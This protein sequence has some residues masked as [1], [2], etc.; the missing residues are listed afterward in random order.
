MDG[1]Y[2]ME[3]KFQYLERKRLYKK[4]DN[5]KNVP[6]TLFVAP[7]GY[8]KSS[9]AWEYL[10][11]NKMNFCWISLGHSPIEE[12][13]L[14]NRVVQEIAKLSEPLSQLMLQSGLPYGNNWEI[15]ESK[16]ISMIREELGPKDFYLVLDDYHSCNGNKLSRFLTKLAY[17]DI[18]GVHILLISRRY[19]DLPLEELRLKGYCTTINQAHIIMSP[20]EMKQLFELNGMNLDEQHFREVYAYTDGWVAAAKLLWHDYQE[21]KSIRSFGSVQRL[22]KESLYMNLSAE[23]RKL[24]YAFTC[25]AELSVDELAVVTNIPITSYRLNQLMEKT[26]F[27][28]YNTQNQKYS[29]NTLLHTVILEL[30][31][32]NPSELF[33]RYACYQEKQQQYISALEYYEKA[34]C[35]EEILHILDSEQRFEIMNQITDF[36]LTFFRSCKDPNE[37]FRHPYAVLS[38]IYMMLQSTDE[39]IILEG[40]RFLTYIKEYYMSQQASAFQY[41]DLLGELYFVDSLNVFHDLTATN[42]SL[43]QAWELRGGKSSRI[44]AKRPYSY[45]VPNTLSMYHKEP[46]MLKDEVVSEIEY[47]RQYMK[48]IYNTKA[49]LEK[50]IH[51][52]YSLET[53]QVET[54]RLLAME[55]LE[56]AFFQ[57]QVCIV[58]NSF[59]ILLRCAIFLGNKDEFDK[60]IMQCN[61]FMQQTK[62]YPSLLITEYDL[63]CGYIYAILGQLD[64][65]PLWLRKRQLDNCNIITRDSKC[66]CIIYGH[67]LCQK[68]NWTKLAANAEET[69]LSF[70]GSRHVF[71]EIFANIFYSITHWYTGEHDEALNYFSKALE[72]SKPDRIMMP[73]A[74][75]SEKLIPILNAIKMKDSYTKEV[76][77]FCA[78]WQ[79]GIQSF[80]K[81]ERKEAIFTSRELEIIQLLAQGYRNSEI[82]EQ[83]HIA[84]ITVEKNLTNIYRKIGVT[85]RTAAVNWYNNNYS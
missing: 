71:P 48:L 31:P 30:E 74:E 9:A 45:G 25:F 37:L 54:A 53:G 47:S 18:E 41:N 1:I 52:E 49:S 85:N 80:K 72:L 28:H 68:K 57:N 77:A 61:Q 44:F 82:G 43:C 2:A 64:K 32:G 13:W 29:I 20:D 56:K 24:L 59:H 70:T 10:Q 42:Q 76:D 40:N 78:Q 55:S 33:Y 51:A 7:M 63:I 38:C 4:L 50:Y 67:Y 58:L 21:T 17:E 65:I 14:W 81:E 12:Q 69:V 60:I 3:K 39:N 73:F 75:I 27:F 26:V 8:G 16:I 66:A 6:L 35:R 83:I 22:L 46:G 19:I 79:K 84:R 15:V 34:G 62:P 23:E 5:I 11:K 36:V